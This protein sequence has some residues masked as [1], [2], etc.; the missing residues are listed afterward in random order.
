MT[1][2]S[3]NQPD[4]TPL[5]PGH[6][7]FGVVAWKQTPLVIKLEYL[8]L[9]EVAVKSEAENQQLREQ[10]DRL[11]DASR[12][13]VRYGLKRSDINL[14][15][16]SQIERRMVARCA[17]LKRAHR[18]ERMDAKAW[19]KTARKLADNRDSALASLFRIHHDLDEARSLIREMRLCLARKLTHVQEADLRQ[20]VKAL[21]WLKEND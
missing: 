12:T 8:K 20:R 21:P 1:R 16:V 15:L 2:K 13:L 7:Q 19:R 14:A 9:Q 11:R 6:M 18:I 5:Q 4:D 10:R 3:S 17:R